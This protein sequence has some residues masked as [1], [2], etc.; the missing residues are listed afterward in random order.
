MK[1]IDYIIASLVLGCMFIGYSGHRV[2]AILL[3]VLVTILASWR[4][5]DHRRDRDIG[6]T[7]CSGELNPENDNWADL[8]TDHHDASG[9]DAG[10]HE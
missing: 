6:Q 1:L 10:G 9:E 3:L 5:W 8:S 7:G 2:I 4:F